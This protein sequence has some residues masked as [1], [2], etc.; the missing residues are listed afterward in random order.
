D[1]NKQ[2]PETP[3][4]PR[5][6][7]RPLPLHLAMEGWLLQMSFAGLT[8]WSAGSPLSKPLHRLLAEL[9]APK[10]NPVDPAKDRDVSDWTALIAPAPFMDA[11]TREA[12]R[13]FEDF[14][15]G[16]IAYQCHSYHRMREMPPAVWSMGAAA[17]RDYGGPQGAPPVVFV[18]SLVNR[19]YILD[20]AADRSLMSASAQRIHSYLLDWG[21]PGADEREF[22]LDAYINRVLVPA[23]EHV[24]R[25][26]GQTPMVAGYCM[27]GTLAVAPA[28]LR[29][30]LVAKLVLLAAPWDFH[31][32]NEASRAMMQLCRPMLEIMIASMGCAPVDLLQML[33]A[34]LDPTLVGRKFRGF[35]AMDPNTDKAKRFVELEDWL[36]DGV[37]LAGPVAREV[38]FDWYGA[39]TPLG[40]LWTVGGRAIKPAEIAC[41]TLALIPSQDRIVPPASA[42]VLAEKIAHAET[43]HVPLGH[44]GMIAGGS[45]A[46]SVYPV[47]IDWLS[48]SA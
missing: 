16:V 33:F 13:Q 34:S 47:V 42:V 40:D 35:A 19:A 9:G 37:P 12:T 28:V 1:S 21:D 31:A 11:L 24:K 46:R 29:P 22:D 17:L 44:I 43:R 2:P 27:G 36:N 6:G 38:L 30:D 32:D 45:A 25:A 39:N 14:G 41:P 3:P 5:L 48:A 15:R 26:T 23:L 7:P 8:P 10:P 4:S 20:L 18:P